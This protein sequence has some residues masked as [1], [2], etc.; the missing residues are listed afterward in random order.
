VNGLATASSEISYSARRE[1]LYSPWKRGDYFSACEP[2]TESG[3]CVE[4]AR[5]AYCR[6]HSSFAFDRDKIQEVLGRLNF[7]DFQFFESRQ[8]LE[9]RGTHCFL[10]LRN[11]VDKDKKLAVVAFRGTDADDP[12][13]LADD[14]DIV[15]TSW[16]KGGR[17]H[18]GFANALEEI[19]PDLDRALQP[20]DCRILFTGHS[21]GAAMAT[22]LA[23]ARKPDFLYT[24]GSPR[25]GDAEFVSRLDDIPYVRYVD[26]CDLV[27][28]LPPDPLGYMHVGKPYYINAGRR[29]VRN[30]DEGDM[31]Q[32]QNEAREEY[33]LRYSWRVGSV[34]MRDLADHA[35]TNYVSAILA[36]SRLP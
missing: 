23:S 10:V 26:C 6:K 1:D 36:D 28:R 27:A 12:F 33:I 29:L 30:L 5:L 17:V 21:L 20:I 35:P 16:Q 19:W 7:T 8:D 31:R 18:R 9:G 15:L 14:A 4:M 34:A 32:D 11:L 13:D 2:L 3:L 24:F 25:V 22:L